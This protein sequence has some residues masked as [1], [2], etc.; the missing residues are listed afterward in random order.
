MCFP[1]FQAFAFKCILYCYAVV[2][3]EC[4]YKRPDAEVRSKIA[5]FQAE[6][7]PGVIDVRGVQ[8]S[9]DHVRHRYLVAEGPGALYV[10]CMGTKEARDLLADAAYL[11]TPLAMPG[12]VPSGGVGAHGGGGG[13]GG[14]VRT[15]GA[16][17]GSDAGAEGGGDRGGDRGF[18]GGGVG[19]GRGDMPKQRLM[20]HRGFA[21]RAKVMRTPVLA[22]WREARRKGKRLVLCGHS[23]GGAVAA[24]ATVT[25]LI[26]LEAAA[27]AAKADAIIAAARAAAAAAAEAERLAAACGGDGGSITAAAAAAA[28]ASASAAS[29]VAAAAAAAAA[30]TV[31]VAG[32]TI[33]CVAFAGPPVGNAAVRRLMAERGG[34]V[35]V[36]P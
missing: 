1:G 15:V 29:A 17:L 22:L 24:L 31:P 8:V 20:V 18:G 27:A 10:A 9:L 25:L 7:P 35:Q 11:Q 28:V 3:C 13:V 16:G 12:R 32:E 26:E 14:G 34:A 4:V 30:G 23:L 2:L 33:R 21:A 5:E 36:D 19:G 6:F